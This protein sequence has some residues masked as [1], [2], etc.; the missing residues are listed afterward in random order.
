[1]AMQRQ[2]LSLVAVTFGPGGDYADLQLFCSMRKDLELQSIRERDYYALLKRDY[3]PI[4]GLAWLVV[5]LVAGAGVFSGL[6]TMYASAMGRVGELAAL[7]T[8]GFGRCALLLGLVQEGVLLSS[9]A[10]LLATGIALVAL[11]SASIQ[12]TMGAFDLAID[13]PSV[14]LVCGIG[15]LLGVL[16]AVP[17]AILALRMPI[18]EGL[19][20]V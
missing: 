13:G 20:A 8:I 2:D 12:F 4:R 17:P 19:K 15:L 1:M 3:G 10:T 11:R 18:V 14:L 6:N 5:V 16:G 7:Q 9:A